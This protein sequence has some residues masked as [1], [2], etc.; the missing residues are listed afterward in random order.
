MA[1]AV[2][3]LLLMVGR[4]QLFSVSAR[5]SPMLRLGGKGGQRFVSYQSDISG[6][7]LWTEDEGCA[8]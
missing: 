5:E 7:V 2:A 4:N 1:A 6:R 3:L 8:L